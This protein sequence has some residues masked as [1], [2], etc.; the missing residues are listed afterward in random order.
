MVGGE[1]WSACR[2]RGQTISDYFFDRFEQTP[3]HTDYVLRRV[4][5]IRGTGNYIPEIALI[6]GSL[7]IED[8]E[9]ELL[10]RL[11]DRTKDLRSAQEGVIGRM[12]V[13]LKELRGDFEVLLL[14][15]PPGLSFATRA[16]LKIA[17]KVIVPFR[18]DY[19]SAYAVDRIAQMIEQKPLEQIRQIE[20]KKR[21]YVGVVNCWRDKGPEELRIEEI[22]A[23]HPIMEPECR[24]RLPLPT[25][26]LGLAIGRLSKRN[27]EMVF[28]R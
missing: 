13:M 20:P 3:N 9:Q 5:D 27:M 14:D 26:L 2:I 12:S 1:Q 22:S 16:A 19:V 25:H 17:D 28:P 24:S 23:W 11:F 21:R 18:P 15:C 7:G 4:G 8:V 10:Y 6:P